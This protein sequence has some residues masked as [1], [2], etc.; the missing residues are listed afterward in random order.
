MQNNLNRIL[1]TTA[2]AFLWVL[3]GCQSEIDKCVD[4]QVNARNKLDDL[5]LK[6]GALN[7]STKEEVEA[8]AR[9]DCLKAHGG[10]K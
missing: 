2:I 3:A 4:A 7:V 9:L 5:A 6:Y 1:I 8:N 10:G